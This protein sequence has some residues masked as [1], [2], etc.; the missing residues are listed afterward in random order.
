[1]ANKTRSWPTTLEV[2][3]DFRDAQYSVKEMGSSERIL[4]M[5]L[6]LRC[7]PERDQGRYIAF[8][9]Y[10]MLASDCGL[11]ESTLR[12]AARKLE[13]SGFIRR[14]IQLNSSNQFHVN[15][16][17]MRERALAKREERKRKQAAVNNA[18]T[19]LTPV[20]HI[21]IDH[22]TMLAWKDTGKLNLP[23]EDLTFL[24]L[25]W[26]FSL[27]PPG[28]CYGGRIMMDEARAWRVTNTHPPQKGDGTCEA[29]LGSS[30]W[31]DTLESGCGSTVTIESDTLCPICHPEYYSDADLEVA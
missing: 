28:N 30:W 16:E 17:M 5:D 24:G 31:C 29:C 1:M 21:H 9:S 20:R 25:L 7:H 2:L 6:I 15:V 26:R 4:L 23:D 14:K 27:D 8:P 18:V 10:A 13:K 11:N 12:K 22:A 19:F 3:F